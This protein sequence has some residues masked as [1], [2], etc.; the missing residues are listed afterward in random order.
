[1]CLRV[2]RTYLKVVRSGTQLL[3]CKT[4]FHCGQAMFFCCVLRKKALSKPHT[5]KGDNR[6]PD[7]PG[8]K[9]E[10]ETYQHRRLSSKIVVM[11]S[12]AVRV[13]LSGQQGITIVT[14][15]A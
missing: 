9:P 11:S 15:F 8:S 5:K 14:I 2:R 3:T 12:L 6:T 7:N 4:F 10:R 1:M 13:S